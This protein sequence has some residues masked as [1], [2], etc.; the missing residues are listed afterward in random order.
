M[1][2]TALEVRCD[3]EN[4]IQMQVGTAADD[5]PRGLGSVP[6]LLVDHRVVSIQRMNQILKTAR[7]LPVCP[8]TVFGYVAINRQLQSFHH[9]AP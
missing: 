6:R 2:C 4:D 9:D 3:A 8:P 1:S 7:F 5:L